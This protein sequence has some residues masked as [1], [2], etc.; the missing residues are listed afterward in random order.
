[1]SARSRTRWRQYVIKH[2]IARD[3]NICGYC[4]V[5]L[6]PEPRDG[7]HLPTSRTLDHIKPR[8]AGG[9]N[10]WR[11][12]MLACYACNGRKGAMSA[13]E[14]TSTVRRLESCRQP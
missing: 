2:L 5:K 4:G 8:S 3:G 9:T 1:M 10:H 6:D 7:F 12:I 14:F 13:E 11:N